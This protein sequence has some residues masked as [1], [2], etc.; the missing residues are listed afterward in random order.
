MT[1][2][3]CH[4]GKHV[5]DLSQGSVFPEKYN[6]R[7]TDT[8]ISVI[9]S[10]GLGAA[11]TAPFFASLGT[12]NITFPLRCPASRLIPVLWFYIPRHCNRCV[13]VPVLP[14]GEGSAKVDAPSC[15]G[16]HRDRRATHIATKQA[17]AHR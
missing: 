16:R 11:G 17:A 5:N 10:N 12:T 8:S 14:A 7:Q 6:D 15:P 4:D 13:P 1:P 2:M 3:S 9:S